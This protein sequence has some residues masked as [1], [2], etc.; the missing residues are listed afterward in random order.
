MLELVGALCI[1]ILKNYIC[2]MP[3]SDFIDKAHTVVRKVCS[4]VRKD[5]KAY[6]RVKSALHSDQ[7]CIAQETVALDVLN[8][9]TLLAGVDMTTIKTAVES[10]RREVSAAAFKCESAAGALRAKLGK[11]RAMMIDLHAAYAQ[12]SREFEPTAPGVASDDTFL[13]N[14]TRILYPSDKVTSLVKTPVGV[15]SGGGGPDACITNIASEVCKWNKLV[16]SIGADSI[17]IKVDKSNVV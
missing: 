11:L 5:V 13:V 14:M 7:K 3:D 6:M 15:L 2:I 10:R 1:K 17:A 12:I 8:A 4:D 9:S 16:A